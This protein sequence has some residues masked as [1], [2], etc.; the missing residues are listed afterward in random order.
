MPAGPHSEFEQ[1]FI[2][3][4]RV[5]GG[6]KSA[7]VEAAFRAVPRHLF[8][9]RYYAG[10]KRPRLIHLDPR[11]PTRHQLQKIYF[12][13]P[14]LSHR[15][16]PSSTSQPS[17]VAGMLEALD[18]R[19]GS[20][21][22]EIGAGTGW[23]AG[24]IAHLASPRGRVDT[25]DIQAEVAR[26]ARRHLRLAGSR[27]ARVHTGDGAR[28]LPGRAPFDRIVTTV[29]VPEVFPAW[30][31][32]LKPGGILLAT[33]AAL[34]GESDCLLTRFHRRRDHLAGDV[35]MLPGFMLFTGRHAVQ[36][37]PKQ[38]LESLRERGSF[39]PS[40]PWK[41][42]QEYLRRQR[43]V[44]IAFFATL[45]GMSF[46]S[47]G[48]GSWLFSGPDLEGT[49]LV[50]PDGCEAMGSSDAW[51]RLCEVFRG[52]IDLGAPSRQQCT[53]E[54]WPPEVVKR[55]PRKGWLLRRPQSQMIVRLRR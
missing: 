4:L 43:L 54:V 32:Q 18:V 42:W 7:A 14:L 13:S 24:L 16:P 3:M 37:P 38:L 25:I 1:P 21:V 33:L 29:T 49:C 23:N 5:A 17:L 40:P 44:D 30:I 28:G 27:N 9:E 48:P 35:V 45:E 36:P 15:N 51:E 20:R 39:K 53:I 2:D 46:R 52:W 6:L 31:D 41:P 34:P 19:P 10:G 26:L 12:D 47:V 11:R 8:I 22:M 50:T 55:A